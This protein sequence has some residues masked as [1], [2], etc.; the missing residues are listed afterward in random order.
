MEAKENFSYI[1][2]QHKMLSNSIAKLKVLEI[3][4]T[5]IHYEYVDSGHKERMA[6]S[7]FNRDHSLLEE[8]ET[9]KNSNVIEKD[10]S[11]LLKSEEHLLEIDTANYTMQL[12]DQLA[13]AVA[14][15]IPED[16]FE[17]TSSEIARKVWSV[18]SAIYSERA[19]FKPIY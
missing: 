18:V 14:S 13:I 5:S 7:D 8:L 2:K 16:L 17:K 10:A 3:T 1:V 4:A 15:N 19:Y 11:S 6:L 9:T 12:K